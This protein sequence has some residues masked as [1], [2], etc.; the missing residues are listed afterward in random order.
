MTTRREFLG[1]FGGAGA[2]AHSVRIDVAPQAAGAADRYLW[3]SVATRLAS[4]MLDRLE[5][6]ELKR[7][8]PVEA[9]T[10]DTRRPYTHLE[11]L[12]RLLA[13]LAPWLEV[14]GL[15]GTEAEAQRKV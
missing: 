8:M 10:P 12:G 5:H 7:T 9:I 11:A 15:A 2:L 3:V 13:G 4:P 1:L 14:R 6:R